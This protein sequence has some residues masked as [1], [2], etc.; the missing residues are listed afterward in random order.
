MVPSPLTAAC[1]GLSGA[2]RAVLESEIASQDFILLERLFREVATSAPAV[3]SDVAPLPFLTLEGH[4]EAIAWRKAGEDL[5]ARGKVAAFLVA[6]GQGTRLGIDG[7]KGACTIGL[8]SGASIFRL[9]AERLKALGKRHGCGVPWC[10]MT[11]P[12]NDRATREHFIAHDWFGLD[13]ADVRFFPQGM[14]CALDDKGTPLMADPEHLAL[15]PDGNGGCFRALAASGSLQWLKDRG[16]EYV[17][18]FGVDNILARV[19]DPAFLGALA[20][21]PG[22]PTASKVVPKR[23]PGEKVGIFVRRDGLPGVIEYSDLDA[24][25][26]DAVDAKGK[27]RYD[28]GNIATHLFRMEALEKLQD[29]PLPWH[30]AFKKVA[31][32]NAAQGM[33]EPGA[34]NA[35]KFE[36]F[37]FDAFPL[38]GDMRAL[39]V[40][41]EEEFAPVKNAEGTDSPETARTML[42]TLHRSWLESAGVPVKAGF[43]YEISPLV[44]LEGEGLSADVFARELGKGIREFP[45]A[46]V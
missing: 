9:H 37:L 27:L 10:I 34:P 17:F 4:P 43:L 31:F 32:W 28:G 40:R 1:Q 21:V 8:P 38:L 25:L 46:G 11:S 30:G 42:G 3:P 14:V 45:A 44:S 5:L 20:A 19:C 12:L 6:G 15:V 24:S 13:P 7:P 33:V 2:A 16:V 36:Q 29:H 26:R 39:G 18:L 22:M 41:R 23:G 35:W